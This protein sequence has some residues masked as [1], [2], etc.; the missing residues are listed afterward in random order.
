MGNALVAA[1]SLAEN[2]RDALVSRI[3]LMET[4][5]LPTKV[6]QNT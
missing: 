1:A 3:S 6:C 4:F 5:L 2:T